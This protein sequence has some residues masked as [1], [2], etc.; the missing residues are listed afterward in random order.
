MVIS[1]F[2]ALKS[3]LQHLSARAAVVARAHDEQT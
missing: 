2:S 1:S 3:R